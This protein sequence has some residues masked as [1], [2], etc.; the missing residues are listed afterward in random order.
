MTATAHGTDPAA[1][2]LH[3]LAAALGGRASPCQTSDDPRAQVDL[4]S[5]RCP[6]GRF[7]CRR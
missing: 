3:A 6:P 4:I 7:A 1:A 2:A 5:A